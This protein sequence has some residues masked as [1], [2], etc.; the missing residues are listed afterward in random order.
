MQESTEMS[1]KSIEDFSLSILFNY[2]IMSFSVP[3]SLKKT[4]NASL[5]IIASIGIIEGQT[6]PPGE[7]SLVYPGADGKLVYTKHANTEESNKDN[8]IP[9]F[10]N[11][12]YMGGGVP[13]PF[14]PAKITVY[15]QTGD[16]K[17]RIQAAIDY[18]SGLT[19][20]SNGFRGAVLLKAGSYQVDAGLKKYGNALEIKTSGVVLRGEGQGVDGTILHTSFEEKHQVV[21]CGPP[22]PSYSTSDNTSITDPYVGCGAT[23]FNVENASAYSVGD[24]I[25]IT[26]IP[27]QTWLDDIYAN[28]YMGA[29]DI[30]WTTSLY[31]MNYERRITAI[32]SNEISI[33]SPVILP[34]Q[35]RF[36]GGEI[37]KVRISSGLRT[38]QIGVEHLRIVGPGIT[39]SAPEDSPNRLK[40]AV[41]LDYTENSWVRGIT[42]VH[43][44][45]SAVLSWSSHYNTIEDC[46]SI[47][48]IGPKSG[49]YRYTYYIDGSSSHNLFQR[50]YTD[51]GRHDYVLG[52]R[53][54]G[55]NVFLDGYS[56]RGGT[57]GPHQRW[58]TGTLFDNLKLESVIA[59]EHR[60]GSGSGHSWAGIQSVIWNTESPDIVC[61]TPVGHMNYAIGAI[62]QA[63]ESSYIGAS[64]SGVYTGYYDHH[65]SHVATRSLYLAQLEDRLDSNAVANITI[66]EQRDG[67]I[68]DLLAGWEGRGPLIDTSETR[69]AAPGNLTPVSYSYADS[70]GYVFLG[71]I[72]NSSDETQF[73]LERSSN[74]GDHFDLLAEINENSNSYRDTNILQDSYHYRLKAVNDTVQSAYTHLYVDLSEKLP[75]SDITFMVNMSEIKERYAGWNVWVSIDILETRQA[76]SDDKG[77]SILTKTLSLPEGAS[78]RYSFSYQKGA[79]SIAD[80]I[81]ENVLGNCGDSTGLRTL[82]VPK[83]DLILPAVLFD[84]CSEATPPGYDITDLPGTVITGSNDDEPWISGSQGA[85]SPPGEGVSHLIDNDIYTKYLVRAVS[86]WVEISTNR[87]SVVN[88]YSI[89]SANDESPRDPRT[90]QFQGL[91]EAT[92]YWATL[93]YVTNN[94]VWPDYHTTKN[95]TF[96]NEKPYSK[97]R[98][99]IL[100]INGDLQGLMQM[101]ELQIWGEPGDYVGVGKTIALEFSVY[102]NPTDGIVN[103]DDPSGEEFSCEIYSLSGKKVFAQQNMSSSNIQLDLGGF[104]KGLYIIAIR[105][106]QSTT[107][108]KVIL[109]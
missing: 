24:I 103:I 62:G 98:L 64:K 72:D 19:P 45:N 67:N 95:W 7:S 50:T 66:P 74:G 86:S 10:S 31:T 15:P 89:T 44:S 55:P 96:E 108:H 34:M 48:P 57:T 51:D 100:A 17:S 53:T 68:Y 77:D 63:R 35:T 18:V 88:G 32:N 101:A 79:D 2:I 80:V 26:M 21:A 4:L 5:I 6:P 87:N 13:I 33:H 91:N 61:E 8:T 105:T 49:G 83:T 90:W 106:A 85:G 46:A 102:P 11:S 40:S 14:V 43:T 69:L 97:Y 41:T 75:A 78:L 107:R 9:D 29:D 27:N 76:M 47:E 104:S 37:K 1:L 36:G 28:A 82:Q 12:G 81:E 70:S 59:L 92:G 30:D 93:H 73:I 38:Q 54:P 99:T 94:P 65:G 20:D 109:H 71:W 84:S 60:N 16:D 39:T 42:V 22:Q 25:R 52:P 56:T 23:R 58:A 3:P